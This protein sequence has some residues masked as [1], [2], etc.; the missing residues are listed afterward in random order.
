[1]RRFATGCLILL[2]GTVV[3]ILGTL[4]KA[5]K[6]I[7]ELAR[8]FKSL[9]ATIEAAQATGQ[10]P[11]VPGPKKVASLLDTMQDGNEYGSI[12]SITQDPPDLVPELRRAVSD[13]EKIRNRPC[14]CYVA[15]VIKPVQDTA[16]GPADQLPFNEMIGKIPADQKAIDIYLV[17]PGG[18]AEQV[19][20]FVEALRRRFDVVEFILPDK[21][22]SAG[23]LWTLSGD[24]IWMDSRACIGPIDPQVPSRDGR[25]VPAQSLLKLLD[26]IKDEGQK[27]LIGGQQPSWTHV[28]LLKEFDH[29]QIGSAIT[30]SAY[31]ISMASEFLE[32]YKF[33]SW[34]THSSTGHPVTPAQ[35]AERAL[36]RAKALCNHDRWK[37]HGHGI[38]RD[39]VVKEL[40]ITVDLPENTAGLERAIRSLWALFY[41][42]M[43]RAPIQKIMLS[44][45][46]V[47]VRSQQLFQGGGR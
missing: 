45:D 42:A 13:I 29:K 5:F 40:R 26:V 12:V 28:L 31:S 41:Y 47:F 6:E 25:L 18:S 39:V 33:K 1:V 38:T 10:R 7:G 35:R 21:A 34:A 24:K 15:N 23:T 44:A 43:D 8:A 46:Y 16:I 32:K 37:A 19:G 4:S 36:D 30:A 3:G 11:A 17:P 27:A 9:A 22:M 14:I 2:S 20:L